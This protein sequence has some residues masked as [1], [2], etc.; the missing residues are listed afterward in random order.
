MNHWNIGNLQ[1]NKRLNNIHISLEQIKSQIKNYPMGQTTNDDV[2]MLKS[3]T[4]NIEL[5]LENQNKLISDIEAS[6]K[7]C[8]SNLL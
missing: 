3:R 5:I 4:D 1:Q 6:I 8:I 2:D 7:H